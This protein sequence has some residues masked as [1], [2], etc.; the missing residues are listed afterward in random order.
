MSAQ[1]S[2]IQW[3]LAREGQQFGPI[4]E[5]ELA[6][7]IELGHLQPS[8]LLWRDGFPDW[9]PAMVI[10]PA[11]GQQATRPAAPSKTRARSA[12]DPQA[13]N[14]NGRAQPALHRQDGEPRQPRARRGRKLVVLLLLIAALGA[15]GWF[16]YPYAYPY[17]DRLR[18]LI[19]S[20]NF[21]A[22]SDA[23][24]IAD[25]KSLEAPPLKGFSASP[26]ATDAKLQET[27]L[28][29]VIK[30]EFPD[31]YAQRLNEGVALARAGSDEAAIGQQMAKKLVELRRQQVANALSATLPKLNLVATAFYTNLAKLKA[32]GTEPCFAFISQG[33]A[34]PLVV[35]M[36]QGSEHT[37]HLQAQLTAVFEAIADGRKQP[38]VYPQPRQA[39]YDLLAAELT[40]R[41][42]SQADMALFSDERALAQAAPDKVCQ[43]VH[44]W[45][46]AQLELGNAEARM[47]LLVESLR[48]VVAG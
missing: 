34:H 7:F 26:E 18:G 44:D 4:S 3:Y 36:L 40:K 31:W 14:R 41:G 29:R 20:V 32:Q 11:P 42:W 22:M 43:M 25:R 17:R 28:W 33:E 37:V 1:A 24:A 9:R 27:A 8:D 19:A 16:A 39:D 13:P 48:P 23:L 12:P 5:A 45:F 6:K 38:R 21:F 2:S 15:A 46:A 30:R 35:A 47:R 10:F